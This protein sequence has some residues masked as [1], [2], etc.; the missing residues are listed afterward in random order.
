MNSKTI[1]YIMY[2][3]IIIIC[4]ISIVIAVYAQFF[5]EEPSGNSYENDISA[6]GNQNLVTSQDVKQSFLDLFTNEFYSNQYTEQVSKLD[7]T[8][9]I[10]YTA[11]SNTQTVDGK[12]SIDVNIPVIN[13]KGD[14][15]A[16]Y[17]NISQSVFADKINAIMTNSTVYTVYN[18]DYTSYI[19]N[20]IL[21][22]ID[23][24]GKI[25]WTTVMYPYHAAFLSSSSEGHVGTMLYS[26][27]FPI[28]ALIV[29][30]DSCV[31]EY[32]TGIYNALSVRGGK[33]AIFFNKLLATFIVLFVMTLITFIINY[34]CAIVVFH[35]GTSSYLSVAEN[36]ILGQIVALNPDLA[37]VVYMFVNA[38]IHSLMGVMCVCFGY[39]IKDL[40]VVYAVSLITWLI[41]IALPWS[42][43]YVTQPYIEQGLEWIIPSLS[44]FL[45]TAGIL[46]WI[47]YKKRVLC[48]EL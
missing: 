7:D 40:K 26:Y 21:L 30:A 31:T 18:L 8:K 46:I 45:I 37:Y 22:S 12:Y 42:I 33:K 4:L 44:I 15:P 10:V 20:D 24:G 25:D 3:V 14:V 48:D 32:K 29:I 16:E 43:T 47:A 36:H 19:N 38:A 34:V 28:Y 23:T 27:L 41:F 17:N 6:G 5:M 35:D 13:I 39:I 9:D 1:R 2:T 11:Y